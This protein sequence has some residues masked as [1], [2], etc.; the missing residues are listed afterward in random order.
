MPRPLESHVEPVVIDNSNVKIRS[1]S[2]HISASQGNH[3]CTFV[4]VQKVSFFI[5][6]LLVAPKLPWMSDDVS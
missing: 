5:L 2:L 6:V 4:V 3:V 1:Q